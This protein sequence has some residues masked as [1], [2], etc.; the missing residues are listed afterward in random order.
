[1]LRGI[2]YNENKFH[3][4]QADFGSKMTLSL[5]QA[6]FQELI[7]QAQQQGEMIYRQSEFG[8]RASLPRKLGVGGDRLICLR[9]GLT[10]QIRNA[11]LWQNTRIE[12]QHEHSFPLVSKFYLS[13]FSRIQTPGVSD[14]ED[15]YEEIAGC[16]YLYHLPNH[17][18]FE[19]WR[20]DKLIQVVMVFA[21]VDYFRAFNLDRDALLNPLQ[22]LIQGDANKRFHQSFGKITP[23]MHQVLQQ[24]LHCPYQG[25]TQQLYLESKAL[26]LLTLQFAHWKE[27]YP[28]SR[29]T[30]LRSDDI[31][32][33]HLAK[34]ILVQHSAN[35]PSLMELARQVGL[36]DRKLKQGFRQ[37]FGTT[38][39]GYLHD[40]RMQ[41]AQHL[42]HHPHITV[43][44]VAAKVGYRNP[45]AFSTA[46]RRKFAVS[47]KVYQ[48]GQ[49]G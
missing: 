27:E 24:I 47:P 45:E 38:V 21:N 1:M 18:E 16:N 12:Q 9:G 19:E 25:L 33:L 20:S 17:T 8:I 28:S 10:L 23:A 40:Y 32:R 31:E 4:C 5:N 34:E 48:L 43:A 14:I 37:L 11:R 41:Q 29:Q 30:I 49:R 7:E 2:L 44:Q 15:D 36:N 42:L 39:F 3:L 46:F 26:E 13:S 22:E 6:D 35:P